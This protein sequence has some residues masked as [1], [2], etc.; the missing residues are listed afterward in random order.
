MSKVR[1]FIS[2]DY[3]HDIDIKNALVAQ[4][5]LDDS[6]FEITDMSVKEPFT[7][8][9]KAKVRAR[10][11]KV[12]QV[13]VMC[14]QYTDNATGVSAELE[15]AQEEKISYFLLK[16]RNDKDCVKPKSAKSTDKIYDWTWPN[17]KLLIGG[18][19]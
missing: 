2:F 4:A 15:I 10:I 6:P 11:K 5:K 13:C 16:G 19:R 18:S 3:D 9:W 1:L 14:G 7:G 8:D 12:E 17:L